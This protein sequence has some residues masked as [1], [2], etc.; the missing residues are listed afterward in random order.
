MQTLP[1]I[2]QAKAA[3]LIRYRE[4]NGNFKTTEEIM[5]VPGIKNAA[6][7]QIRD[8]ITVEQK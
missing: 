2:G 7:E 4:T 3:A 8:L 5:K 6:Y 1:G